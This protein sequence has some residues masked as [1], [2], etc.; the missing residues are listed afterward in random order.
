MNFCMMNSHSCSIFF[1]TYKQSFLQR[2]KRSPNRLLYIC[3]YVVKTYLKE[4]KRNLV[5]HSLTLQNSYRTRIRI[6]INFGQLP[7]LLPL[8]RIII[9][10]PKLRLVNP[11]LH[12][13]HSDLILKYYFE[14]TQFRN[15]KLRHF[16]ILTKLK[17]LS[18]LSKV[19]IY[20][21]HFE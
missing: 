5:C 8:A 2:F 20:K 10:V 4:K 3:E 19:V 13:T 17:I 16:F 18:V 15:E 7:F 1:I 11:A 21:L 6:R 14:N 12:G 9:R